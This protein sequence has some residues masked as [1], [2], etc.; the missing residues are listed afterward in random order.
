V[1]S[2]KVYTPTVLL[3]GGVDSEVCLRSFL[4]IGI[5]PTIAT[6]RFANDL[7]SYDLYHVRRV[8][9]ELGLSIKY[10]D[11]NPFEFW[12]SKELY[13]ITDPISCV[14]PLLACHLWLSKQV[15]GTPII[16]QGEPHLI[17]PVPDEYVPGES[18]YL[19]TEWQLVESERLCSL[20]QYFMINGA[21]AIPGFFQYLPEQIFSF[22]YK[23]PF[24]SE[25]VNNR[26]VGKLG[27][28]SSK[29][30]M[31]YQFYPEVTKRDKQTGVELFQKTHDYYR[32]LLSLRYP[33]SDSKAFLSYSQLKRLLI[34]D[35]ES[36]L[37]SS[38]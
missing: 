28:R 8:A 5:S 11:L 2:K 6:L 35:G 24:L 14:S 36:L 13:E 30:K 10:F 37:I 7:N 4:S 34:R 26:V 27:T 16:A 18:D 1:I 23:N 9:R 25:L 19:N 17:K 38:T 15:S 22:C 3:S 29:N 33:H 31:I 21:P 32:N 12:Q 20:Y